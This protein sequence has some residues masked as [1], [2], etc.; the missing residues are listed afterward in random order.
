[1]HDDDDRCSKGQ[2][3]VVMRKYSITGKSGCQSFM[4]FTMKAML[5]SFDFLVCFM[6]VLW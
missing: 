5:D 3:L 1:M 4:Y 2:V 6:P